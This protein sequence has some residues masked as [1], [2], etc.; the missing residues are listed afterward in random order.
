MSYAQQKSWT[1][2]LSLHDANLLEMFVQMKSRASEMNS[3]DS[4]TELR[5]KDHLQKTFLLPSTCQRTTTTMPCPSIK[6]I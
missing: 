2:A 6:S 3:F 1:R 4:Q 5:P